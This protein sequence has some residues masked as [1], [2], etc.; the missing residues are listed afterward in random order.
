MSSCG[1]FF[2]TSGEDGIVLVWLLFHVLANAINSF[3]QTI[4][5]NASNHA[6]LHTWSHHTGKVTDIACG[7]TGIDGRC[8]TVSLDSTCKVITKI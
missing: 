7:F 4:N 5:R 2:I 3:P 6:P 1:S 8:A